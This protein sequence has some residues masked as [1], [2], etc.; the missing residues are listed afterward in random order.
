MTVSFPFRFDTDTDLFRQVPA[1]GFNLISRGIFLRRWVKM[2][3]HL[4]NFTAHADKLM[5]YIIRK[6]YIG[7]FDFQLDCLLAGYW[8]EY[9]EFEMFN[10]SKK[11]KT[12][13]FLKSL[14]T[15]D[16]KFGR[17]RQGDLR[18]SKLIAVYLPDL[19]LKV[20]LNLHKQHGSHRTR[21]I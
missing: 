20:I 5:T 3:P 2:K 7:Y 17:F 1:W 18:I 16:V 15:I 21:F 14:K 12:T 8:I 4:T 19:K 9:L 13:F 10:F 6:W 11:K